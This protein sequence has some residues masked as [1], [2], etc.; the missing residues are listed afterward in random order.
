MYYGLLCRHWDIVTL[1]LRA[2]ECSISAVECRTRHRES[3]GSNPL[4]Y[5]PSSLSCINEYLAL[6][7]DG[8]CSVSE[9]FPDKSNWSRNG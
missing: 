6:D 7:S 2:M 8:N 4:C 9:H 1:V 3:P 5:S